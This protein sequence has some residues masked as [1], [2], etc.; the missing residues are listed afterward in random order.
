[1]T[2]WEKSA[3]VVLP[4]EQSL[5]YP[6]ACDRDPEQNLVELIALV[7]QVSTVAISGGAS[8]NELLVT[9]HLIA[10]RARKQSV[11]VTSVARI[12]DIPKATISR[13]LTDMRSRGLTVEDEDA[14]DGRSH[15]VRLSD[16]YFDRT[17]HEIRA[18]S[19]WCRLPEHAL[20]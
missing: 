11:T 16:E 2:K 12:L 3:L 18:I 15:T 6:I 19:D 8:L 1:M 5:R 13:I 9:H 7:L 10:S 4:M 20:T 14:A 17:C